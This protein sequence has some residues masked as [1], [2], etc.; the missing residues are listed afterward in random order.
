M[1][2]SV[3]EQTAHLVTKLRFGPRREMFHRA[4]PLL[5]GDRFDIFKWDIPPAGKNMALEVVLID[6]CLAKIPSEQEMGWFW[7]R[8]GELRAGFLI[9]KRRSVGMERRERAH[10]YAPPKD[11]AAR[12]LSLLGPLQL[13][14]AK[15]QAARS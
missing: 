2:E 12:P 5:D 11:T 1:P 6:L 14:E 3:A 10:R 7:I 9:R 8:N 13:D 15:A 4:K